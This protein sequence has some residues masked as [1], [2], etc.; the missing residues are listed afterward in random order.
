MTP[1]E[2]CDYLF[3]AAR[4]IVYDWCLHDDTYDIKEAMHNYLLLLINIFKS[5]E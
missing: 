5:N 4:G 3:I 2:I 1:E